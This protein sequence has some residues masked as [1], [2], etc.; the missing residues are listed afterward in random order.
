LTEVKR[1]AV[2]IAT[3]TYADDELA[4]LEAPIGDAYRLEKILKNKAISG[5]FDEISIL[6]NEESHLIITKL[7]EVY[8]NANI[9][10]TILVYFA[11]HG[12]KSI[13]D[14][15]LYLAACNTI[16]RTFRSTSV[17]AKTIEEFIHTSRSSKKILILD[18]CY[19]GAYIRGYHR[20]SNDKSV[21]LSEV[22]RQEMGSIVLTSTDA[23]Q[24][25]WEGSELMKN[26]KIENFSYYTKFFIEGLESGQADLNKDGYIECMEINEYIKNKMREIGHPQR[27]D[28]VIFRGDLILGYSK[29]K[30]STGSVKPHLKTDNVDIEYQFKLG[31]SLFNKGNFQ[32][33]LES[34]EKILN[35]RMHEPSTLYWKAMCLKNLRKYDESIKFFDE[36]VVMAEDDSDILFEKAV[37]LRK[38]GRHFD[39]YILFEKVLAQISMLPPMK[40]FSLLERI[41]DRGDTMKDAASFHYKELENILYHHKK[42]LSYWKSKLEKNYY[43]T[44]RHILSAYGEEKEKQLERDR[45]HIFGDIEPLNNISHLLYKLGKSEDA[46]EYM[47]RALELYPDDFYALTILRN[48][49]KSFQTALYQLNNKS[50]NR[51]LSLKAKYEL[52]IQLF[53]GLTENNSDQNEDPVVRAPFK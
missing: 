33:A 8:T 48:I 9:N 37:V 12:H 22:F 35:V 50:D 41:I 17:S 14:R 44:G 36:A 10:D 53:K 52:N 26:G 42:A 4:K 7:E 13:H 2:L 49:I 45:K 31:Q 27:P 21:Q 34:F 1:T 15:Q 43:L 32:Q 47:R 51:S 19:S 18:C 46:L 40:P 28:I 29:F 23:M 39:A 30:N 25:A 5:G 11:G 38:L 20:A 24:Y 3:D 6:H 16:L